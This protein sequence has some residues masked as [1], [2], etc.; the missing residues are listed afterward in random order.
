MPPLGAARPLA[1]PKVV[2][3]ALPNGMRLVLL[4]DHAQPALWLRLAL[5]AG[6]IRDPKAKVGLASLTAPD[7][8]QRHG[9][10]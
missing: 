9:R 8:D 5:P 10:T 2:E 1:L 4:E 7:A 3:D 6:S